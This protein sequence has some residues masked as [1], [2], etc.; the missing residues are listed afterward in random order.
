[1]GAGSLGISGSKLGSTAGSTDELSGTATGS[2]ARSG[3]D[4]TSISPPLGMGSAGIP[5]IT[6][7]LFRKNGTF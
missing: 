3:G 2:A 1:M 6:A 7:K 4:K 5:G